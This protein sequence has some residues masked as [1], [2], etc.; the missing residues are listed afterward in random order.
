MRVV[1]DTNTVISALLW[2]GAPR[3]VLDAA[4][5]GIIELCTSRELLNELEEVLHRPKFLERLLLVGTAPNELVQ[6]Y[7]A[8][9]SQF[10]V[11]RIQPVILEDPDDDI[12]IACALTSESE[13]IVSGDQHLLAL[14]KYKNIRIL[15][16]A[17]FLEEIL[18]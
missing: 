14:S 1:L 17:N 15:N 9:S 5:D 2:R 3:R 18:F 4:R 8:A 11:K 6:G 10:K 7:K 12:V 13:I 16:S